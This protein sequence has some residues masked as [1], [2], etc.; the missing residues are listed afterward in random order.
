M[1]TKQINYYEVTITCLVR[2]EDIN[3]NK[4]KPSKVKADLTLDFEQIDHTDLKV[5]VE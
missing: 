3:G 5:K 4:I 1:K 2:T